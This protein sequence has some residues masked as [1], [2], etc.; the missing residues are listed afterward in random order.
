MILIHFPSILR[1][2][3]Y[4]QGLMYLMVM[5]DYHLTKTVL[6]GCDDICLPRVK[7]EIEGGCWASMSG[8]VDHHHH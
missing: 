2:T 6:I 5:L 7:E 3:L 4:I 1:T 8:H